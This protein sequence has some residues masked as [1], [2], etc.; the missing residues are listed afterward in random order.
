MEP[1]MSVVSRRLRF[2]SSPM[3]LAVALGLLG[4]QALVE[5]EDEPSSEHS[6]ETDSDSPSPVAEP[7][8]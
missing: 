4:T 7:S 8:P 1:K 3:V 2:A 6:P 5:E